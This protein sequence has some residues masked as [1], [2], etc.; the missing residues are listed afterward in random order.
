MVLTHP[1]FRRMGFARTLV[2]RV[3]ER[4]ASM[5]VKTLKLDATEEGHPLYESFGFRPEQRIERWRR[6]GA[7]ANS[8]AV[9]HHHAADLELCGLDRHEFLERRDF[10]E[11]LSDDAVASVDGYALSRP[12]R[13]HRY[14]GPCVAR[15]ESGARKLIE[16]MIERRPNDSWFWD[17]LPANEA[18]VRIAST[19]GFEPVRRLT[20][21]V[22]GQELRSQ[23]DQIFAIGGF[24]FG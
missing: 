1:D 21:M 8:A 16:E 5:G 24:D 6:S 12:G 19:L 18:A 20:R 9:P 14:L 4:A 23:D 3:T 2:R 22:R 11:R 10:L 7:S 13:I 15:D 17:L